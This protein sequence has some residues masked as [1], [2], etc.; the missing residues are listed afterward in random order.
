M[1][2]TRTDQSKCIRDRPVQVREHDS[3]LAGVESG[4]GE[5]RNVEIHSSIEALQP[6][7]DSLYAGGYTVDDERLRRPSVSVRVPA[8]AHGADHGTCRRDGSAVL[9]KGI[10]RKWA[11]RECHRSGQAYVQ[12]IAQN[13]IIC[14]PILSCSPSATGILNTRITVVDIHP[15]AL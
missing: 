1:I 10:A 15:H 2:C 6:S 12:R 3:V 8:T 7:R 11:T 5:E 14:T 9:C 13:A 4:R